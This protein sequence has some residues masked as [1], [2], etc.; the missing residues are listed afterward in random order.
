MA[1]KRRGGAGGPPLAPSTPAGEVVLD[2][3][4]VK[5]FEPLEERDEDGALKVYLTQVTNMTLG[6]GP[7]GPK[8]SVELT[9]MQPEANAKRKLFREFSLVPQALPFLYALL[10]ACNSTVELGESFR[11]KPAEW[12]GSQCAV[13]I[14]NEPFEE[15]IRSRVDRVYAASKYRS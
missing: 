10:K 9:I 11:F 1:D 7:K 2:F 12:L 13:T 6:R 14:K 5:P 8:V 4:G 3:S 15:Q